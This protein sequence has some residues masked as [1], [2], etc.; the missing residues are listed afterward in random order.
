VHVYWPDVN[1]DVKR[2]YNYTQCGRK[3]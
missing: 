1:V 3:W 2:M